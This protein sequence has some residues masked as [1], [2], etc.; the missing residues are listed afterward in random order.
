MR[1]SKAARDVL[2]DVGFVQRLPGKIVR[3]RNIFVRHETLN[4]TAVSAEP[5]KQIGCNTSP[6]L[7]PAYLA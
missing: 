3:E 2:L 4:I 6:R 5:L 7:V 1:C